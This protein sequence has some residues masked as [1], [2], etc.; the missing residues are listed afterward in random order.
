MH[1]FPTLYVSSTSNIF[2][3]TSITQELSENW[4]PPPLGFSFSMQ[5]H[6]IYLFTNKKNSDFEKYDNGFHIYNIWISDIYMY[7]RKIT[8]PRGF[9][10]HLT[11]IQR[12][13]K[14]CP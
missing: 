7:E 4:V 14:N 13:W 9:L 6:W 8:P 1:N 10:F 11:H 3:Q 5:N 12:H 2:F